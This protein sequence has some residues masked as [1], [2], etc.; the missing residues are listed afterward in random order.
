MQANSLQHVA[1][2]MDGN[3]RWAVAHG[4]E[5]PLGHISGVEAARKIIIHAAKSKLPVLSLFTLSQEN[6]QRSDS[7]VAN[8]LSLYLQVIE[9]DADSLL[10]ENIQVKFIGDLSMVDEKVRAAVQQL[11]QKSANNQG[12]LLVVAINYSGRWDIEQAAK[13]YD[14]HSVLSSVKFDSFLSTKGIPD[15]DLLIRTAGDFRISNY[16]LWQLSYTE[17]H[18][19]R[20]LWPDFT[21]AEFD[22]A[23]NDF[24][25]RERRFGVRD[26]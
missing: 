19:T 3:G 9:Q 10:H 1:I 23:I 8:L 5:K 14:K 22:A 13:A 11:E 25:T 18:F 12:M 6:M 21:E 7:E 26:E 15:P 16:Y 24:Y 20:T 17:L 2:I 4:K